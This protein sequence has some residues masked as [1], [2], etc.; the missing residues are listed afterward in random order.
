MTK[1][2]ENLYRMAIKFPR[3]VLTAGLMFIVAGLVGLLSI[4]KDTSVEAFIPKDH[5]S[6]QTRDQVKE[7]FG[8]KDPVILAIVSDHKDGIYTKSTLSLIQLLHSNVRELGRSCFQ[9]SL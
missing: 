3:L 8:L 9:H 7:I 5:V 4:E 6:V 1:Y 2:F